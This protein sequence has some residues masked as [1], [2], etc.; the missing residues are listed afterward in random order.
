VEGNVTER[1]TPT[2]TSAERRAAAVK[3]ALDAAAKRI[4][5]LKSPH[6]PTK[7]R[8]KSHRTVPKNFIRSMMAAVDGHADLRRIGRFDS[9]E[10]Q[11]A[12]QFEAAFRSIRDQIARLLDSLNYT[13]DLAFDP[14]VEKAMQTYVIAKGLA[15]K[16]PSLVR[17]VSQLKRDLGRKGPRKKRT[18]KRKA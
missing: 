17:F 9:D 4:P 13:I 5:G 2:V 14:V 18:K 8:M 16:D 3:K 1:A 6:A 7:K 11:A 12:L 10:A 15:R